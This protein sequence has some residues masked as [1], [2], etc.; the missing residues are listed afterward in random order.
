MP[1]GRMA[2]RSF[3]RASLIACLC[4]ADL[5]RAARVTQ[6][7]SSEDA[8]AAAGQTAN[9]NESARCC[10][11]GLGKC[12]LLSP[13]ELSDNWLW[14]GRCPRS[15]G[16]KGYDA[17]YPAG[18]Y[19][20]SCME[21]ASYSDLG[22]PPRFLQAVGGPGFAVG[23][24]LDWEE[25]LQKLLGESSTTDEMRLVVSDSHGDRMDVRVLGT[26]PWS[27]ERPSISSLDSFPWLMQYTSNV[28]LPMGQRVQVVGLVQSA[29][30]DPL[31]YLIPEEGTIA[32]R[33]ENGTYRVLLS[34]GKIR[35]GVSI[36]ELELVGASIPQAVE[37]HLEQLALV[38]END[39]KHNGYAYIRC[40]SGEGE[41]SKMTYM[42]DKCDGAAWCFVRN[43]CG[44]IR[45]GPCTK[46]EAPFRCQGNAD[47][48]RNKMMEGVVQCKMPSPF[49]TSTYKDPWLQAGVFREL[50]NS[51]DSLL[52][53]YREGQALPLHPEGTEA[54]IGFM[55]GV[56][57]GDG[58]FADQ[59][60]TPK[61]QAA[62]ILNDGVSSSTSRCFEFD[63]SAGP[64]APDPAGCRFFKETFSP[65]QGLS[66]CIQEKVQA[67]PY[68]VLWEKLAYWNDQHKNMTDV[69]RAMMTEAEEIFGQDFPK[70]AI[71]MTSL[72]HEVRNWRKCNFRCKHMDVFSRAMEMIKRVAFKNWVG[73]SIDTVKATLRRKVVET[74]SAPFEAALPR[75]T[76]A[77]VEALIGECFKMPSDPVATVP[78]NTGLGQVPLEAML[79]KEAMPCVPLM[80]DRVEV[81][82]PPFLPLWF[83][84]G[85]PDV[86]TSFPKACWN[87][88]S[89]V[90]LR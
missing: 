16:Y 45:N 83:S 21:H 30:S 40:K 36:D 6:V 47:M 38:V 35:D 72:E 68:P 57:E 7:S 54:E 71:N 48:W 84:G 85:R 58:V 86:H 5:G 29:L 8:A 33:N 69:A 13:A 77:T 80:W 28:G 17:F 67:D 22:A 46:I 81:P 62:G 51:V 61:H 65:L 74:R 55:G 19:P 82:G 66:R 24:S 90:E 9:S 88:P 60:W 41:S 53:G 31:A 4:V 70:T 20:R 76:D 56:F 10:C 15:K 34:K 50:Y 79:L 18:T 64:E 42:S 14:G 27:A 26:D 39:D 75:L 25:V 1:F 12:K 43:H 73:L 78:S 37:A 2:P 44:G 63:Y 59:H 49:N 87:P 3:G 11:T 23:S 32:H 52:S 89:A